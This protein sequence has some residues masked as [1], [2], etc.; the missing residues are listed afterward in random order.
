MAQ[1]L[2]GFNPREDTGALKLLSKALLPITVFTTACLW[3]RRLETNM[4]SAELQE[5]IGC[6]IGIA[7]PWA[8]E[9]TRVMEQYQIN[10]PLRQ[11][12]FLAQIAHESLSLICLKE[13]STPGEPPGQRYEGRVDLGNTSPGDGRKYFGRGPIQFTGKLNYTWLSKQTGIDYVNHPEL[14]E[15][16]PDGAQSAALYWTKYWTDREHP[17]PDLNA[18]ADR[19]D[20]L[21]ISIRVN[22]RGKNGLPNGFE[23]R[24]TC[25]QRAKRVLVH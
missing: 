21:A 24:K 2:R 7:Q 5:V 1:L 20:L 23:H 11:A 3:P 15:R 19:D 12:H 9:L 6:P 13:L 17:I 10:T 4:T 8:V 18:L 22:G 25:L 14:L 16:I